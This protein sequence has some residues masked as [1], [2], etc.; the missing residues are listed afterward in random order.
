MTP[1]SYADALE[2]YPDLVT[3]VLN[4]LA[5]QTRHIDPAQV[6]WAEVNCHD[7]PDQPLDEAAA[8]D[9]MLTGSLPCR[10]GVCGTLAGHYGCACI[11]KR[12]QVDELNQH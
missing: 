4:K 1:I 6:A 10:L 5:A 3:V 9:L 12:M 7:E 11:E 8:A 2:R